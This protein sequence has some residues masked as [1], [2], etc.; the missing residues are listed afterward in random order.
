MSRHI[1][2]SKLK[3][4]YLEGKAVHLFTRI[5]SVA[6]MGLRSHLHNS[7]LAR[8]LD[9]V[10]CAREWRSVNVSDGNRNSAPAFPNSVGPYP[11]ALA[12][13][14]RPRRERFAVSPHHPPVHCLV[15]SYRAALLGL[16]A[17]LCRSIQP[18]P[19]LRR[20]VLLAVV[21]YEH[22]P[23][24]LFSPKKVSISRRQP[25]GRPQPGYIVLH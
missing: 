1:P 9:A 25:R 18:R 5:Y 15:L 24:V 23:G 7:G 14:G 16:A 2:Q 3:H 4:A 11:A 12:S 8:F 6:Q 22:A 20:L 19:G 13:A 17:A 21:Q 10:L